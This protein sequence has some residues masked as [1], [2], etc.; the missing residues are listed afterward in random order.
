M[1]CRRDWF[2][3]FQELTSGQVLLSNDCEVGVQGISTINIKAYGGSIK[4][5]TNFRYIPELQRNLISTGT[6][7]LS[8]FEHSGIHG[9]T[10]FYKNGKLV[11]QGTLSG[12]L[13]QLDGEKFEN[14]CKHHG[15]KRHRTCAFTPQQN[16]VAEHINMT[17]M[18]NVRC[19]LVESGLEEQ[20]WAETVSMS[21]YVTN[22]S[23]S[24]TIDGSILVG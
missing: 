7:Y 4:T 13:Y 24:S 11:L 19:F 10:R 17:L 3:M 12:S 22:M 5:L 23:P 16:G 2:H 20:L 15:I 8:G 1:T 18:E 21:A 14:F 6:L 9:K